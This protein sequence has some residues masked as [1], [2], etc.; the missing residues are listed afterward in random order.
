MLEG[1]GLSNKNVI[2]NDIE[3]FGYV[4]TELVNKNIALKENNVTQEIK[5]VGKEEI[6]EQFNTLLNSMESSVDKLEEYIVADDYDFIQRQ[7]EFL[8]YGYNIVTI[9]D[10]ILKVITYDKKAF[11]IDME[12]ISK[13]IYSL[14]FAVYQPRKISINSKTIFKNPHIKDLD[15]NAIYDIGHIVNMFYGEGNLSL[16]ELVSMFVKDSKD[17]ENVLLYNLFQIKTKF[18]DILEVN[19]LMSFVNKEIELISAICRAEANGLPFSKSNYEE[20]VSQINEGYNTTLMAVE[21]KLGGELRDKV[22]NLDELLN[23]LYIKGMAPSFNREYWAAVDDVDMQG[24]IVSHQ[25]VNK[26]KDIDI[27]YTEDRLYLDYQL[28]DDYGNVKSNLELDNHYIES[29][30]GKTLITGTYSNLYFRIFSSLTNLDFLINSMNNNTFEEDLAKKSFPEM[31]NL[32]S[33]QFN[34]IAFLRAYIEGYF[35]PEHIQFFF[36]EKFQSKLSIESIESMQELFNNNCGKIVKFIKKFYRDQSR[37]KRIC[38][39]QENSLHQYVKM[40]ESDILKTA[41]LEINEAV[42]SFNDSNKYK[43]RLIGIQPSKIVL[44]ADNEALNIAVDILNRKLTK[45]FDLYVRK[46]QAVCNVYASVKLKG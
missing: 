41:I 1:L 11:L 31:D 46:V 36:F 32:A 24:F 39:T 10:N 22:D 33:G 30:D 40:T 15:I 4:E 45:A 2:Y 28:Y 27:N 38:L 21:E 9:S 37:D 13:H 5:K 25:L 44:E 42:N 26:Y 17:D 16:K 8:S 6:L 3:G 18:N 14:I 34:A 19:S 20:F 23:F 12:K 43:I 35:E 7:H 29:R